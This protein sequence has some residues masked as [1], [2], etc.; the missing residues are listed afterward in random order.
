MTEQEFASSN[1]ARP[2]GLFLPNP[3]AKLR[4]QVA[5]VMRFH[6]YSIRT[7]EMYWHWI[8]RFIFFHGKKHPQDLGEAEVSEFLSHLAQNDLVA[9]ATQNQALNALVFLYRQVIRVPLGQISEYAR[10][11]RPPRLPV[12]LS[13]DEVSR[14]LGAIDESHRLA[15]RILYGTG[16]R[17]L[18]L[19]RLRVKDVDF[20]RAQILVRDGKG[21]KDR[22]AIFPESIRDPLK[23]HLSNVK[24]MHESDLKAGVGDVYLPDALSRK[25]P[26][27]AREWGWQYVFPARTLSKD[28]QTGRVRRHHLTED[29]IQ[30]AVRS[31]VKKIALNK[32]ATSHTLRHS[33]ATH[34]LEAGY[35]IRTVQ[36]LLGHKDVRTT[37][38]YTHVMQKPGLGTRSPL[39]A[40]KAVSV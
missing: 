17:L 38:I 25:F 29:T 9:A 11:Q 31:A 39:D 14:L 18:E 8:R 22:M 36:D 32:P 33:F 6:H 20:E 21:Y 15:V 19:L 35:D 2:H 16:M 23:A 13:S 40:L 37:M 27:A 30:R 26:N 3:K 10:V 5:E 24:T 34:L 4:Q 28:P 1:T 12:V 7:E